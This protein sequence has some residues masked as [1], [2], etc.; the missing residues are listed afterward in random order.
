MEEKETHAVK[1]C[2][3]WN[4]GKT[5]SG[6]K[7]KASHNMEPNKRSGNIG[8]PTVKLEDSPAPAHH[9]EIELFSSKSDN[10]VPGNEDYKKATTTWTEK[11]VRAYLVPP[12]TDEELELLNKG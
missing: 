7:S 12:F 6:E 9:S 8:C 4:Y 1:S 11:D 5:S 2:K 3:N 10:E